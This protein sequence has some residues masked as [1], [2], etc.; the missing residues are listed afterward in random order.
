[1]AGPRARQRM[2]ALSERRPLVAHGIGLSLG[3]AMP[4]DGRYIERVAQCLSDIRASYYSEH[5]AFTRAPEINSDE[6]LPVP[7]TAEAASYVIENIRFLLS[8][9]PVPFY[10]EN[11]SYYFEYPDS[12][13]SEPDFLNRICGETGSGILLD[14]ENVHANALNH[15]LDP[16]RFIDALDPGL[17][18]AIHIAGG[19]WRRG[20][21]VDTHGASPPLG[22]L[23]VLGHAL[24]RFDPAVVI[25][26]RDTNLGQGD[27]LMADIR[28][29]RTVVQARTSNDAIAVAC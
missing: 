20:V 22:A 8:F 25:V 7:R 14:V 23:D 6:L 24:D 26:E 9:L 28:Q 15:G 21:F 18:K 5:L 16:R 4:L 29:V 3:S 11:I 10:L 2:S 27:E 19:E 13:I 1:G 12:D 17:V